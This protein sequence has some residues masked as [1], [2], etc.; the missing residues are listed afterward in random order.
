M[1][2]VYNIS[3]KIIRYCFATADPFQSIFSKLS[4]IKNIACL[5][6]QK[7]TD[8]KANK[9]HNDLHGKTLK[10]DLLMI[11][12]PRNRL[13]KDHNTFQITFVV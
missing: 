8:L 7:Q 13:I 9:T 12:K 6:H 3:F 1:N 2:L 11:S 5:S 10:V 4:L